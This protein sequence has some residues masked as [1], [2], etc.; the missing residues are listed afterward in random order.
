MH[1]ISREVTPSLQCTQLRERWMAGTLVPTSTSQHG[2]LHPRTRSTLCALP[3]LGTSS[4]TT[5]TEQTQSREGLPQKGLGLCLWSFLGYCLR[6]IRQFYLSHILI[7][8]KK[9]NDRVKRESCFS[10]DNEG[11]GTMG[12]KDPRCTEHK[13]LCVTFNS[14][15]NHERSCQRQELKCGVTTVTKWPG[16]PSRSVPRADTGR[17]RAPLGHLP[18]WVAPSKNGAYRKPCRLVLK[19]T[20]AQDQVWF[21][22]QCS[23]VCVCIRNSKQKE[24]LPFLK[25]KIVLSLLTEIPYLQ[26]LVV[27]TFCWRIRNLL[28]VQQVFSQYLLSKLMH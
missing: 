9:F 10:C 20:R 22:A 5:A 18:G 28:R 26:Y 23:L 27:P 4:Q 19:S 17:Q 8:H 14:N 11:R 7:I 16:R 25:I 1:N 15:N 24:G 13:I 12:W 3:H 21:C 2:C 6:R